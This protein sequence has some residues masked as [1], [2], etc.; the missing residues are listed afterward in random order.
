VSRVL[1][2]QR[3]EKCRGGFSRSAPATMCLVE[4]VEPSDRIGWDIG[5]DC[6]SFRIRQFIYPMTRGRLGLMN[7]EIEENSIKR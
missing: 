1:V 7:G 5:F 3:G 2:F 4:T 6:G